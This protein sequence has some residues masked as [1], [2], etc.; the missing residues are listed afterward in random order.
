MK[1]ITE[2]IFQAIIE[3]LERRARMYFG[4]TET[5][6]VTTATSQSCGGI[7]VIISTDKNVIQFLFS[8]DPRAEFEG[9]IHME[10]LL[11]SDPDRP[12]EIDSTHLKGDINNVVDSY[13]DSIRCFVA[14]LHMVGQK[15]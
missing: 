14:K 15:S 10:K 11:G 12:A 7:N 3:K 4:I 8:I 6:D 1:R 9:R 2:E 13:V 5:G